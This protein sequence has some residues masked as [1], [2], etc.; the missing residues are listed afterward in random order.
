[1]TDQ[2]ICPGC[3]NLFDTVEMADGYCLRCCRKQIETAHEAKVGLHS[4]LNRVASEYQVRAKKVVRDCLQWMTANP[5][6]DH[7]AFER[8]KK[9]AEEFLSEQ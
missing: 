4:G 2:S 6:A 8:D 1:M 7:D 3:R 5:H 9:A